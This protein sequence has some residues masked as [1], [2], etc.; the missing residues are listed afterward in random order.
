MELEQTETK[1]VKE[2][3]IS[4]FSSDSVIEKYKENKK[5]KKFNIDLFSPSSTTVSKIKL[6]HNEHLDQM[7]D[8]KEISAISAFH[9]YRKASRLI[10]KRPKTAK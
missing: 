4:K 10:N 2:D 1:I 7:N 9:I 8:P 3:S 6:F 5:S